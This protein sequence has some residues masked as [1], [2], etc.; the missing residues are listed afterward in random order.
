MR[1]NLN[2]FFSA[3]GIFL[4]CWTLLLISG[5]SSHELKIS[6]DQLPEQ[7]RTAAKKEIAGDEVIEVEKELKHGKV[8][9]AVKYN[10][11]GTEMEI[12]YSETGLLLF[13][14]LE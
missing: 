6:M 12:E 7:I 10:H 11:N 14:G 9:Y 13:K 5:C 2:D 4:V 1:S 8:I 3:V